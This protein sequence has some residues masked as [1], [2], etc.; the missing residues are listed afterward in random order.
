MPTRIAMAVGV[1]ALVWALFYMQFIVI[2]E[3][4]EAHDLLEERQNALAEY[5]MATYERFVR[6]DLATALPR[7]EKA[8]K[9]PLVDDDGLFFIEA[10]KLV[11]PRVAEYRAGSDTPATKL[12]YTLISGEDVVIDED[13]SPYAN[14]VLLLADLRRALD[15]SDRKNIENTFRKILT[16]KLRFRIAA[17]YDIP[18]TL[19]ALDLLAE[20]SDPDRSL[21]EKLLR[22]GLTTT[23]GGKIEGLQRQ[24][25]NARSRFTQNDFNAMAKKIAIVSERVA[26][27]SEDFLKVIKAAEENRS[28][29]VGNEFLWS[30]FNGPFPVVFHDKWYV[31]KEENGLIG[32]NFAQKIPFAKIE[33][34]MRGHRLMRDDDFLLFFKNKKAFGIRDFGDGGSFQVDSKRWADIE[35]KTNRRFYVKTGLVIALALLAAAIIFLSYR[36]QE[37]KERYLKLQSNFIATVSH[38]LR[39]PLASIRLLTETVQKK[40]AKKGVEDEYHPRIVKEIDGLTFL[41]ENILSYNRLEKGGWKLHKSRVRLGEIVVW[42]RD[43]APLF[44]DRDAKIKL[45][46]GADIEI[47]AD[48]DL[49]KLLFLNLARNACRYN[50]RNPVVIDIEAKK[51]DRVAISISDNGVGIPS[52][53]FEKVFTEFYRPEGTAKTVNQGSGLGLAVCRRV[54]GLH[55]G[56]IRISESSLNG[57]TFEVII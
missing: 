55:G 10:G 8:A 51:T 50:E 6:D 53:E 34:E 29:S 27:K 9:D 35:K 20:K 18:L 54:M 24:F 32:V 30:D 41:V 2:T 25:I 48:P 45:V 7:I 57:T 37:R 16:Q 39:T 19:V 12:Y 17:V 38:E 40:L 3:R 52:E 36:Y 56:S 44:T 42:I 4:D 49:L 14:R 28:S 46:E 21:M 23:R 5:A 22:D 43:N 26:V 1:G 15:Q 47:D 31:I 33:K 11:L 13:N